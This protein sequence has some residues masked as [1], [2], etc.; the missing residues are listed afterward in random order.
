MKKQGRGLKMVRALRGNRWRGVWLKLWARVWREA[1]GSLA[2]QGDP[3]GHGKDLDFYCWRAIVWRWPWGRGRLVTLRGPWSALPCCI[4]NAIHCT[5]WGSLDPVVTTLNPNKLG[6]FSDFLKTDLYSWFTM[7]LLS[8]V[9]QSDSVKHIC[10]SILF[11][12]LFH[13]RLLQGIKYSILCHTE[14]PSFLFYR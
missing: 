2:G 14:S 8:S 10:V 1:W 7:L 4:P 3:T 5:L 13:Y 6:A 9:L 12:I 11:Q